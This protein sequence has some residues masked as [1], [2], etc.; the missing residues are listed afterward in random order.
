MIPH[1]KVALVQKI[2]D[3]KSRGGVTISPVCTVD[4]K[5]QRE[6]MNA[7]VMCGFFF[8]SCHGQETQM[9][10]WVFADLTKMD[11]L[12][13][14]SAVRKGEVFGGRKGGL[15]EVVEALEALLRQ[16]MTGVLERDELAAADVLVQPTAARGMDQI[17][18][19]ACDDENLL[20]TFV[21]PFTLLCGE[22]VCS[23]INA[24]KKSVRDDA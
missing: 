22:R 9:M 12:S 6:Q 21:Q 16:R 23:V 11:S 15:H 8:L 17:V 19:V 1:P 20:H 2:N 14:G 5:Y 3:E 24:T 18:L 4:A 10:R 13:G 7:A